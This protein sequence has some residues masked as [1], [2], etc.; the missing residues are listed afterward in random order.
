MKNYKKRIRAVSYYFVVT[1]Q[2]MKKEIYR[3]RSFT[4]ENL[5]SFTHFCAVNHLAVDRFLLWPE[6]AL[7]SGEKEDFYRKT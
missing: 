7:I 4:S 1:N 3:Q 6:K 5:H 2:I